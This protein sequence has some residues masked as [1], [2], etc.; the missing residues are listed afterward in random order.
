M[1]SPPKLSMRAIPLLAL[2]LIFSPTIT[3]QEDKD[4]KERE[5]EIPRVR[6][7]FFGVI[8]EM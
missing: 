7:Q 6:R 4:R 1:Y 2:L 5:D 3:A 8:L